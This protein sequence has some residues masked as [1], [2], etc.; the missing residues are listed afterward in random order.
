MMGEVT[1]YS[2]CKKAAAFLRSK[3]GF[4]LLYSVC[5]ISVDGESP[6]AFGFGHYFKGTTHLIEVKVSRSDFLA[7][8]KKIFRRHA[9]KGIGELRYYCCP[10]GLI[11]PS[12]IPEKWGLIYL[13]GN[14]LEV[15]VHAESQISNRCNEMKIIS[16][17]L[18]R[19]DIKPQTFN[20]KD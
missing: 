16:S 11:S 3:K 20:F 4:G 8:R 5:E 10:E 17:I 19:M 2:L 6:D 9:Y 15:I 1:H 7:D 13:R 12:E 18:R 14:K